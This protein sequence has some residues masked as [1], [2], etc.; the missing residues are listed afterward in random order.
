MFDVVNYNRLASWLRRNH[1][2]LLPRMID[3]LIR[4]IFSCWLPHTAHVGKNLVLGYGGLGVV[5]HSDVKIGDDV[6]ID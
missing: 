6:H 4:L 3:Y 5:I 1:V 2:P